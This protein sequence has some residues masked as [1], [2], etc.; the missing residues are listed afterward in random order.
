VG[1]RSVNKGLTAGMDK[2]GFLARAIINQAAVVCDFCL[3]TNWSRPFLVLIEPT[4]RCP[5]S[6]K[7]CDLPNDWAFP[8]E[9]EL[10][11][12]QWV[13]IL[14]GLKKW[15]S[16]VRE[17]YVSGG[18]PFYRPD[19]MDLL[20]RAHQIGIATRLST[21][22]AF[23]SKVLCDRL[24]L[25]PVKWLKFSIH[26]ANPAV[27]DD[28]VGRPVFERAIEAIRYLKARGYSGNIGILTTVYEGNVRELGDIVRLAQRLGVESVF[29]RPLF[30]NTTAARVFDRPA[31]PDPSCRIRETSILQA[32]VEELKEMRQYG[33]PVANTDEQLDLVVKQSLGLNEGVSGCKMMYE[34]IY[35]HPDGTV[36]ICGHMSLGLVGNVAQRPV[37]EVLSSS[38][39]YRVR[40]SVSRTCRCQG[41]AFVRKTFR[42]KVSTVL[43][44]LRPPR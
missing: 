35:I 27:H 33:M 34:S 29:F 15:S 18:E 28:L 10:S 5:M 21:I 43:D 7:F 26:S 42:D 19:M 40:H 14:R 24:L 39:S 3:R 41:N 2:I 4:L 11:L 8:R 20:E 12:E 32:A 23:C 17:I 1:T 30:G 13:D 6:C 37:G 31:L 22:G 38:E 16:L 25:S 36:E 44:I 9:C